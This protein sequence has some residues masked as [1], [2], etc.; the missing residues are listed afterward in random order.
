MRVQVKR[1]DIKIMQL[2]LV[3]FGIQSHTSGRFEGR[4]AKLKMQ[5]VVG[6]VLRGSL[7]LS[8]TLEQV[9]LCC[10]LAILNVMA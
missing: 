1:S 8:P 7:L 5:D 9:V 2:M 10:C 6:R 3:N 4:G